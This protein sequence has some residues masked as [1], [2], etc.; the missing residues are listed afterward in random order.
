[1]HDFNPSTWKAEAGSPS[2]RQ[3]WS[4]DQVLGQQGLHKEI[5][6]QKKLI[7][8][9]IMIGS[10]M[11]AHGFDLS[12]QKTEKNRCLRVLCQ[13]DFHGKFQASQGYIWRF[14]LKK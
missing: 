13:P 6:S 12:T 5:L 2:L 10:G 7:I 3:A 11:E 1:M 14:C 9:I 4:T 8:M